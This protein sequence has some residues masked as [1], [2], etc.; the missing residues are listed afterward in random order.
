MFGE[1]GGAGPAKNQDGL[2]RLYSAP[3]QTGGK[4]KMRELH[5]EG[6]ATH[7]DPESCIVTREGEG[8]ALTVPLTEIPEQTNG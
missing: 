6:I 3:G 7:D 1:E 8:E 2:R 4:E 5:I